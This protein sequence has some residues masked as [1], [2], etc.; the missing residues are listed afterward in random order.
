M[1][2]NDGYTQ[3]WRDVV[4]NPIDGLKIADKVQVINMLR[5]LSIQRHHKVLDLGC[6]YGRLF[7]ALNFFSDDVY[8]VDPEASAVQEAMSTGYTLAKVGACEAI[9]F[10]NDFFDQ[11]VCWA[12]FEVVDQQ[13]CLVEANRT[14][15]TGGRVLISGKNA[16][17]LMADDAAFTAEKNAY[18]K[19]F[20]Q[21]FTDLQI[22]VSQLPLFG[23]KL[24]SAYTFSKRGDLAL[25]STKM[26][27][28]INTLK[29]EFYEFVV[30]LEKMEPII[31][32]NSRQ[33][34]PFSFEFSKTCEEKVRNSEFDNVPE[35]LRF[36]GI[37]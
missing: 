18:L 4:N 28:N 21:S 9:P 15:R 16:R 26:D 3:Y 34:E 13:R 7:D 37:D 20:R 22:M 36:L 1:I 11:I 24:V 35:Y 19:G 27:D 30:V 8:G 12:V 14:L 2:F 5:G 6:S 31:S 29:D 25:D 33:I 32:F 17:Y 10:T 23:F